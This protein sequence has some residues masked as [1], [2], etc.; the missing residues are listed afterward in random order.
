MEHLNHSPVLSCSY[1]ILIVKK[2]WVKLSSI[3]VFNNFQLKKNKIL[4]S[5]NPSS[6][7]IQWVV[8]A[9]AET[10]VVR[11]S[12]YPLSGGETVFPTEVIC[13]QESDSGCIEERS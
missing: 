10:L 2:I 3:S 5:M 9:M 1:L 12:Q 6:R 8:L 13:D 4:V 7:I 11:E